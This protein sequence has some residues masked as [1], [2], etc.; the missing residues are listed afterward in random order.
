MKVQPN[1][2]L[3]IALDAVSDRWSLHVVRSLALGS[4]RF[5]DVIADTGAPRDVLASRLRKLADD[6]I[7]EKRPYRE[8]SPRDGYFLTTKGLD[9]AR[10]LLVLK[11]W[12]DAYSPPDARRRRFVHTRCGD[13]FEAM[14]VCSHCREPLG[15]DE[16]T[17]ETPK[18]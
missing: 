11:S 7:V 6:E 17:D 10:V 13:A 1:D 9:L 16:L 8:G 18:S 5:T 4:V 12:G 14:V 15:T 3:T 2:A